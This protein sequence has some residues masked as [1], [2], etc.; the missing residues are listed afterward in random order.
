MGMAYGELTAKRNDRRQL[1]QQK[2]L[3]AQEYKYNQKGAEEDQRRAMEMW[4]NTNYHA[5]RAQ[6]EKAGLNV[7]L[8]YESQ[9]GGGSTMGAGT[10]GDVTGGHAPAG[11]GEQGMGAQLGM[12]LELMKAQKENIEAD[13]ANKQATSTKTAGVDTDVA[14]EG[15]RK[16]AQETKNE[17]VKGAILGYERDLKENSAMI[18]DATFNM[19]L[20]TIKKNYDKLVAEVINEQTDAEVNASTR[21][22]Q[23]EQIKLATVAAKLANNLT[24]AETT[25]TKAKTRK[26][27]AEILNMQQQRAQDNYK[28]TQDDQRILLDKIRTEFGAGEEAQWIRRIETAAKVGETILRGSPKTTKTRTDKGEDWSETTTTHK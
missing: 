4:E 27:A 13:T 18:S 10:G 20:E 8:M 15:L 26:I 1:N 17:K 14:M 23:I 28:L 24:S 25:E 16:L 3:M 5:Q 19:Q 6:M 7:G 2:K 22:N 12:Q 21:N 11:G 9:G